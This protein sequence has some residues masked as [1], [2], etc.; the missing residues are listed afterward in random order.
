M[1]IKK[2]LSVAV[3][4]AMVMAVVPAF[5]LVA[6]AAGGDEV[7]LFDYT[8]YTSSDLY[9]Q[10]GSGV[11]DLKDKSK[12]PWSLPN[13]VNFNTNYGG[14]GV[15]GSVSNEH[16][17]LMF[18]HVSNRGVADDVLTATLNDA[19]KSAAATKLDIKFKF[20]SD[21]QWANYQ[22]WEFKDLDGKVF[23]RFF[24]DVGTDNPSIKIGLDSNETPYLEGDRAQVLAARG[25]EFE[26]VAEIQDDG[27][28]LVTYNVGGQ[29]KHTN[30]VPEINGFGSITGTAHY[31]SV[32]YSNMGLMDL[33]ISYAAPTTSNAQTV[34]NALNEMPLGSVAKSKVTLPST[35]SDSFEGSFTVTWKSNSD[36]VDAQNGNVTPQKEITDVELTPSAMVGSVTATGRAK[37][38]TILPVDYKANDTIVFEGTKYKLTG[39][40]IIDNGDFSDGVSNWYDRS[41]T[42]GVLGSALKTPS[43]VFSIKEAN[44]V[45]WIENVVKKSMNVFRYVDISGQDA[46]KF[47][48]SYYTHSSSEFAA[49]SHRMQAATLDTSLSRSPGKS[50][51]VPSIGG[52][53]SWYNDGRE[54]LT[55]DIAIDKGWTKKEFVL[56]KSSL[57]STVYA[58]Y[59]TSFGDSDFGFTGF[60]LFALE[61]EA[62]EPDGF[63][64]IEKKTVIKG[65]NPNLPTKVILTSEAEPEVNIPGTVSQW[66]EASGKQADESLGVGTYTFTGTVDGHAEIKPTIEVEVVDCDDDSLVAAIQSTN[67]QG[68]NDAQHKF[69]VPVAGNVSFEFDVTYKNISTLIKNRNGAG[70]V[71]IFLGNSGEVITA[72]DPPAFGKG[73]N[74][75]GIQGTYFGNDPT[76][77][78]FK[79][80]S[81]P[82]DSGNFKVNEDAKYRVF[83][84][85]DTEADTYTATIYNPDGTILH[86]EKEP[87]GYRNAVAQL[88]TITVTTNKVSDSAAEGDVTVENFRISWTDKEKYRNSSIE[89]KTAVEGTS[90]GTIGVKAYKIGDTIPARN[91][92][93]DGKIYR[94][95]EKSI[96]A[97]TEAAIIFTPVSV[98]D[99]AATNVEKDSNGNSDFTLQGY[100][101][102]TGQKK[103]TYKDAD[104]KNLYENVDGY[105][106]YRFVKMTF[107]TPE[108][109]DNQV[110]ILNIAAGSYRDQADGGN[111]SIRLAVSKDDISA[112][113]TSWTLNNGNEV[114]FNP[115]EYRT[116]D[117]T[118]I[119]KAAKAKSESTITVTLAAEAGAVGFVDET[120]AA[121]NGM[122][123]GYASYIEVKNG[124]KVTV[125][126][127]EDGALI[128]KNG[129]KMNSNEFYALKDDVVRVYAGEAYTNGLAKVVVDSEQTAKDGVVTIGDA[130]TTIKV[131][132]APETT[133]APELGWKDGKFTV[134]F[135]GENVKA[136]D[137]IRVYGENKDG[138]ADEK[139]V[140]S[141][142][143]LTEGQAGVSVS[144]NV[145][146]R[147]YKAVVVSKEGLEGPES[148]AAS[149]YSLVVSAL[150]SSDLK[151]V[152]SNKTAAIND[153]IAKGGVY[154]TGS[155]F[156]DVL[157]GILD[158]SSSSITPEAITLKIKDDL[159]K[160]GIGFVLDGQSTVYFGSADAEAK[161]TSDKQTYDTMVITIAEDGNTVTLSNAVTAEAITLSLDSVNI[162]FVET[163]IEELEAEGA[164]AAQD[165]IP[166]L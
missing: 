98:T 79:K 58:I 126:D 18:F 100:K 4:L 82:D 36:V 22:T 52:F 6:S 131:V 39:T 110:A 28:Y 34:R 48:L 83:I 108:L 81:A 142:T 1:R 95:A 127:A 138:G 143:T 116:V 118:D 151:S 10:S 163:L 136:G 96:E 47:V 162:E 85:T 156:T 76:S 68:A 158:T 145:T 106:G 104:G 114:K 90:L 25:T 94:F 23:A 57:G 2:I 87:L 59:G 113:T 41:G 135:T 140:E 165:F 119:V 20:A 9:T 132:K 17:A 107:T 19:S 43:D 69:K 148:A 75:I 102:V 8:Q 33:T 61:E 84:T 54:G 29:S 103:G 88:D 55:R 30:N 159:F 5:G 50:Q 139:V 105:G 101:A 166:E 137:V 150:A 160:L 62:V 44:D 133:L 86:S 64:P 56:D 53:S 65:N 13:G 77:F 38:V 121:F 27:S 93:S 154:Y 115:P 14:T 122:A 92:Y 112:Y 120:Q 66:T 161:G 26:I 37:T 72:G 130:A 117:I 7:T 97:D 128:T 157:K 99:Y 155:E 49:G 144:T 15:W 60:Q 40:N 123:E 149:V 32:Q 67:T 74:A 35:V 164:D 51:N 141:D 129:S 70:N 89:Y 24:A 71:G 31:W 46:D 146:N 73:G 42:D 63:A 21:D 111:S 134:D 12:L 153:V 152:D 78:T 109:Q 16:P 11:G 45:H 91:I 125:T 124:V 147:I 80:N 3:V